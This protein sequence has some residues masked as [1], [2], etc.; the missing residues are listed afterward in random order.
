MLIDI[1]REYR[2]GYSDVNEPFGTGVETLFIA[3][4]VALGDLEGKPFCASKVAAYLGVPRTTVCRKLKKLE[5]AGGLVYRTGRHYRVR[6]QLLN[7]TSA[8]RTFDNIRNV[9]DKSF[10]ELSLVVPQPLSE[11]W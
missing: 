8:M 4:C 5:K 1:M 3:A 10:R 11:V 9:L 7:C 2:S 6:E